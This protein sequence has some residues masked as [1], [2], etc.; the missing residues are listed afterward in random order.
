MRFALELCELIQQ[1]PQA[2]PG[3][4]VKRQLAKSS[5]S[6]AFNYRAS[7]RARSHT[8]F[9]AKIGIVAEGADE[10]AGW[11]EF[12]EAARLVASPEL[13]RLIEEASELTAIVSASAGT[14]RYNERN[15]RNQRKSK[16]GG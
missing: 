13:N 5:T 8:E 3:P 4:T 2:E 14:A 15:R 10:T 7:C 11:L 6:V 16:A 1:L 12:I 9:T